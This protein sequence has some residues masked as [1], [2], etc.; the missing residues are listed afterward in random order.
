MGMNEGFFDIGV[1][2]ITTGLRD[3]SLTPHEIAER[4]IAQVARVEPACLAWECFDGEKLRR[5]A[6]TCASRLARGEPVRRLEGVPVGVKDIFNTA[7]FPTQM[8]SP[9]WKGFTPGNDARSVFNLKRD[10]AWVPGKTVTAEFAVHAL[11]RTLNPHDPFRNP[12][13]SSTGSAVAVAAGM[14]PVALGTQTAGSIVRPA[15]FC[16]IYGC[17]PSFGLIPR[18]GMLKTTDSLDSVGFFVSQAEDLAT[19]FDALRVHGPDYPLSH[20]PLSDPERQ[21]KSSSRPWRIVVARTHTWEYAPDY[22]RE[23]LLDW[24]SKLDRLPGVEVVDSVPLPQRL[25][26]SHEIHGHIYDKALAY[27]FREEYKRAELVSPVMNEI[28]RRG[29]EIGAETYISALRD[30]EALCHEVDAFMQSYDVL[31][32]LSTAGEAPNREETEKPD[33]ALIWSLT[34][35]PVVSVPLFRSPSGLPFG[36][37]VVSRRYNDYLLFG[38][39]NWLRSQGLIPERANPLLGESIPGRGEL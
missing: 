32:S 13:T 10:G 9:L 16:G 2:S 24:C 5:E 28:I 29:Q 34:H 33:P 17:K 7:D 37:Q 6:E 23:A 27:Y 12:G 31:I 38:F 26:R 22:A 39:L 14:V 25:G 1:K 18:T 21:T 20:T 11:G 3:G 35:L 15:S 8:G 36:A 4:C 30:Q 19:V